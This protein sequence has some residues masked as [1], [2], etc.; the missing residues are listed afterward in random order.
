MSEK[1]KQNQKSPE[2]EAEQTEEVTTPETPETEAPGAEDE[3]QALQA[4][5]DDLND[6][7]L[8]TMAEFDNFRKRSQREKDQIYTDAKADTA[9]QFLGVLDNFER[10]LATE[11]ADET[12][13]KGVQMIY[14]GLC[15]TIKKLGIEEIDPKDQEFDPALHHAVMHVDDEAV[16]A[17]VVVEVFQKGYRMGDKVLRYAMVKVAN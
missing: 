3:T 12:F 7:L 14:D 10:A 13:H 9:S 2:N 15:E 17:S 4:Q 16:G 11:C 8:R 6:K 5:I 1:K